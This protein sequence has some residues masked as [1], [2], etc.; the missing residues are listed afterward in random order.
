VVSSRCSPLTSARVHRTQLRR[1]PAPFLI[2]APIAPTQHRCGANQTADRAAVGV[3]GPVRA[4]PRGRSSQPASSAICWPSSCSPPANTYSMCPQPWPPGCGCW[5]PA[6]RTRTIPV[7]HTV[8]IT[9]GA[10]RSH[11]QYHPNVLTRAAASAPNPRISS[12]TRSFCVS[13]PSESCEIWHGPSVGSRRKRGGGDRGTRSR[14]CRLPRPARQ[15][16]TESS[17]TV[18]GCSARGAQRDPV[19]RSRRAAAPWRGGGAG[20]GAARRGPT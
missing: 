9:P 20:A 16:G 2:G 13:R 5:A 12:Q 18:S 11:P 15:P 17:F 8:T 3:G 6:S 10:K 19:R 1:P 14:S 7:G 4:P